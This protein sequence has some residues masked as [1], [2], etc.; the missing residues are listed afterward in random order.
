MALRADAVAP[1]ILV[2]GILTGFLHLLNKCAVDPVAGK[3]FLQER[4]HTLKLSELG[5]SAFVLNAQEIGTVV[6]GRLSDLVCRSIAGQMILWRRIGNVKDFVSIT[7][8]E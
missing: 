1:R 4:K 6:P 5:N 2:E 7:L 8:E 3:R